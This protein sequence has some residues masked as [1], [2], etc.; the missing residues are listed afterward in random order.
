MHKSGNTLYFDLANT[1]SVS[2]FRTIGVKRA[3]G[4]DSEVQ[5]LG[6][7]NAT[8]GIP[9]WQFEIEAVKVTTRNVS[10]DGQAGMR[11]E[12]IVLQRRV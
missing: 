8:T 11:F 4:R 9:I 2:L 10:V 6:A 5:F 7:M 1:R 3:Y 12:T